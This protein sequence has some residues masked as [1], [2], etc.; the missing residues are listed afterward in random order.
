MRGVRIRYRIAW[1]GAVLCKQISAANEFGPRS[2]AFQPRNAATSSALS[3]TKCRLAHCVRSTQGNVT[4][5]IYCRGVG[6]TPERNPRLETRTDR[7]QKSSTSAAAAA[8][9]VVVAASLMARTGVREIRW[10]ESAPTD[11]CTIYLRQ[12]ESAVPCTSLQYDDGCWSNCGYRC[13]AN[14]VR[15]C[16]PP[17]TIIRTSAHSEVLHRMAIS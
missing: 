5:I 7:P 12:T 15:R 17:V 14:A 13:R 11:V 3:D 10:E 4:P 16:L 6:G 8:A 1:Q 9:V 2:V